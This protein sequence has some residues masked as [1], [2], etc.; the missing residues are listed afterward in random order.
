VNKV[1]GLGLDADLDV[2]ALERIERE[3]SDRGEPVRIEMSVLTDPSLRSALTDR[4]YRL[5]GFE[6][7]RG[8]SLDGETRGSTRARFSSSGETQPP[9]L[10]PASIPR[11]DLS[12]ISAEIRFY[13]RRQHR[14]PTNATAAARKERPPCDQIA[15][16]SR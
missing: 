12:H 15:S 5:H 14:C 16:F 8:L 10:H 1:I 2:A 7:V 9:P 6:N 11:P 4:G 13:P 3:W